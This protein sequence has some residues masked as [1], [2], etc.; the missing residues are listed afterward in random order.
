M[1]RARAPEIGKRRQAE[2]ATDMHLTQKQVLFLSLKG[3][4]SGLDIVFFFAL[5]VHIARNEQT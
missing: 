5:L 1:T 4:P 3:W 2:M